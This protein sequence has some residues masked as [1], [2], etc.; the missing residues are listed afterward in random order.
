MSRTK[1]TKKESTKTEDEKK[2]SSIKEK[3]NEKITEKTTEKTKNTKSQKGDNKESKGKKGDKKEDKKSDKKK[4][5][6][7]KVESVSENEEDI[8]DL[9]HDEEE[10]GGEKKSKKKKTIP[11]FKFESLE[12]AEQNLDEKL[13][14]LDKLRSECNSQITE[15]KHYIQDLFRAFKA[16][17]KKDNQRKEKAET[18]KSFERTVPK[19][20]VSDALTD[21]MGLEKGTKVSRSEALAYVCK[22]V[23]QNNLQGM[24][25]KDA[26][27]EEKLDKRLINLDEKLENLFPNISEGNEPLQ[28]NNL[29]K[30]LGQHFPEKKSSSA[31][32]A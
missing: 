28:Y 29:M 13:K 10:E 26:K 12:E 4:E 32:T 14:N 2:N 18:R 21:F 8:E 11:T 31:T 1:Q 17:K 5:T 3:E 25:V 30:H 24:M 15:T 19:C 27:G 7:K 9:E 20:D 23:K 16:L 22:Y 6:K